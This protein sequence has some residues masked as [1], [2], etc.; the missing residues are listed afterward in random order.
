MRALPPVLAACLLA[1]PAGAQ[2]LYRVQPGDRLAVTV[3]EDPNLNS[4]VLVRPDGRITL[5]IAGS[6]AVAGRSPEEIQSIL[7]ERLAPGFNTPPTVSVSL[8]ALAPREPVVPPVEEPPP[9]AFV[10]VLGEVGKPGPVQLPV[11]TRLHALQAIAAAGGLGRFANGAKIQI[12][13]LD[14]ATGT[15]TVFLLDFREVEAGRPLTANIPLLDG[16][17]IFVPERGLFD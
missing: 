12:R 14:A 2:S 17:V 13:R 16:D 4:Q 7:R 8:V 11:E 5:P 9:P 15:E 1:L 3:I 10:Y 6:L